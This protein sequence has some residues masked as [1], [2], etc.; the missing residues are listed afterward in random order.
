MKIFMMILVAIL[1]CGCTDA[2][3][4]GLTSYGDAAQVTCYSGGVVTYSGSSTG[5][6][7]ATSQSDGWE[8]VD[9]KTN[10]F[11]RVSGDCI[12]RN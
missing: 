9:S 11:L 3:I 7:V 4:G 12:V 6:V 10:E 8:F 5:K 1:M 2:M